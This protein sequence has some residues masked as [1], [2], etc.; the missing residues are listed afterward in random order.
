M[1]ANLAMSFGLDAAEAFLDAYRT[2]VGAS[3]L[4]NPYWD[5]RVAVDFLPDLPSDG[6]P[7]E[8]LERLDDFVAGSVATLR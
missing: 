4:H 8:E 7:S 5:L 6:R 2:V 1:R 3:Y